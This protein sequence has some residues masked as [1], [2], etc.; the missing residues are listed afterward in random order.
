M[1]RKTIESKNE[2]AG[3]DDMGRTDAESNGH[4]VYSQLQERSGTGCP[5]NNLG[6]YNR[7]YG[8]WSA[9]SIYVNEPP[10][11]SLFYQFKTGSH[12]TVFLQQRHLGSVTGISI[13]AEG[14][15]AQIQIRVLQFN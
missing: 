5:H 11:A 15:F 14:V 1:L 2:E 4:L 12:H 6:R 10:A 13:N 9:I 8:F 3:D 7:G